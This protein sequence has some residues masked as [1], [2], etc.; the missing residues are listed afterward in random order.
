VADKLKVIIVEDD[1]MVAHINQR[2]LEKMPGMELAGTFHNGRL[3]LE[4]LESNPVDIVL[5]DVY[6]PELD[7]I[8]L[9]RRMRRLGLQTEVIMV[10]SA[11]EPRQ[12]DELLKL[13]VVDYLVK[14]FTEERFLEAL[15]KCQARVRMAGS[16]SGLSQLAIDRMMGAK[17]V[18]EF[19]TREQIRKEALDM[20]KGLQQSTMELIIAALADSREHPQRT[21]ELAAKVGLSKVTVRRYLNH[22]AERGLIDSTVCYDTGGRPGLR[23]KLK[24]IP[25][26]PGPKS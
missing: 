12:V 7:G 13:G 11:R 5:L 19:P 4:S 25:A 9:L 22:L 15:E 23:H 14:P 3:A 16:E 8:E 26:G 6:L 20:P 24:E 18:Q 21:E 17:P 1:P 10:T 2:Y